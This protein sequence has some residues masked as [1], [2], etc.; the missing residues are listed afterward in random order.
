MNA[1]QTHLDLNSDETLSCR[2]VWISDVHLGTKHA[3]VEE[4]LEFLRVVDCKYLYLVGDL[5]D[6]WELKFRWYWRDDYNVLI[7]KLLRKSR[8]Q[9]KVIYISGNH[10]EF[11]E[12]FMGMRFGSVTI[13]P[14]ENSLG[15]S[16]FVEGNP[17]PVA[18]SAII[19]SASA[20]G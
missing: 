6:G 10:D 17:D 5:I 20:G 8:K 1:D 3:R 19:V 14:F 12:Q 7:Q 16:I 4:L 13:A 2:S 15:Y 18:Q 11:I 9:T